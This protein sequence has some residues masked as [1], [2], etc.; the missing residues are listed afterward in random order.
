MTIMTKQEALLKAQALRKELE[1]NSYLYYVE[2]MPTITDAEYDSLMRQLRAIEAE[3]PELVTPDSPTQHVGGY[4]KPGFTEV[5][6]ITPLLSLANAF[7]PEE[8]EEFDRRV[9]E[10]LPKDAKV[11]YVVEPKIDGLAC[12]IIYENGRFVRAATRGDGMVG[13]NVTENVRTIKN[14][15]KVLSSLPG[16]PIPEL[17]DVRGEVYMPRHAFLKLNEERV[18]RGETEFAN[19]RNAAA[20][21]LRQLD[22]RVTARRSLAF[23]PMALAR[24]P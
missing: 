11:E 17:L 20:G 4:A 7:S 10:G 9:H 14:I 22:P 2:D 12:S 13:E 18:E 1:R 3:Y 5:H 6:H 24:A 23:L 21:S 19:P 15:P 16:V 8:M